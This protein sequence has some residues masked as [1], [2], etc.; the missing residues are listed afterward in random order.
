MSTVKAANGKRQRLPDNRQSGSFVE[1]GRNVR[2]ADHPDVIR[3]VLR[4]T[5]HPPYRQASFRHWA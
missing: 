2:I 3:P 1:P 4:Q 5:V